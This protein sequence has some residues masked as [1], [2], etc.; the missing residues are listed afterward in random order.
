MH[1]FSKA[2]TFII[3]KSLKH[4]IKLDF[5]HENYATWLP[6]GTVSFI[7]AVIF[8]SIGKI[9]LQRAVEL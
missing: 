5:A 6:T 1:N 7:V 2:A 4:Q 3:I 9:K 8:N